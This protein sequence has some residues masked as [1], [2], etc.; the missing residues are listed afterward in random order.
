MRTAFAPVVLLGVSV[1]AHAQQPKDPA[2]R[3]GVAARVKQYPQTTPRAA[4]KL[5]LDRIDAG[6]YAYF[7]A[8]VLDPKFVDDVVIDRGR[9][10]EA[11]LERE[12]AQRRDLQITN[13]DK[14]PLTDRVPLDPKEFR[15]LA[16]VKARERGYKQL[17]KEIEDKLKEDPQTIKD[18]R[19][20]ARDGTF[21][22]AEPTASVA[23][24]S[25]KGRTLYFRKIGD[26][27]FIENKQEEK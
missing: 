12:L 23:H 5:A 11:A 4:L 27:W 14:V 1:L 22:E 3:Y 9:G 17:L 26:R 2:P 21:A 24:E 6:D 7:V 25:V 13:P 20:L 19:K 8:H 16:T 10:F 18:M 15:A